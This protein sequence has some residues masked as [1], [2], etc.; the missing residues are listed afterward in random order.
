MCPINVVSLACGIVRRGQWLR[1]ERIT[2]DGD[3]DRCM[4]NI[5]RVKYKSSKCLAYLRAAAYNMY[6]TAKQRDKNE[7]KFRY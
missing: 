7:E 3:W 1:D 4:L 5:K 2:G 6:I